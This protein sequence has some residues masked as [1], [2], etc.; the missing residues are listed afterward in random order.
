MPAACASTT[1]STAGRWTRSRASC[2]RVWPACGRRTSRHPDVLDRHGRSHRRAAARCR[3]LVPQ[4]AAAVLFK[5]AIDQAI[6]AEFDTFLELGAHPSLGAAVR[7]CLAGRNR[8]GLTI[9]T[10]HRERDDSQAIAAAAASLHVN[11]ISIDWK[12]IVDRRIGS[13]SN[14]SAIRWKRRPIGRS[15]KKAGRHV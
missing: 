12:E 5:Q 4:H 2:A 15:R 10:L 13:S 14:C 1:P 7:A 8:E 9:G 6:D 11:G 3:L